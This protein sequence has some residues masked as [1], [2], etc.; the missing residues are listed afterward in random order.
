[1]DLRSRKAFADRHLAGTLSF[2]LDGPMATW[3]GWLAPWGTPLTLLGESAEQ[4]AAAQRELARI[5]I[6]RPAAAST[7]TVEQW[8]GHDPD[9][10]ADL[11]TATFSDLAA[12]RTG[13][14]A[15]AR[16]GEPTGARA[17]EPAG[18]L[19]VLDV[20]MGNEWRAGHVA[21]AVHIPLPEL[22]GRL[23]E[24]PEGT[25]WVHCGS[26]Y[27]AAAA[28]SLLARSGRQVVHIDDAYS[29][30]ADAGLPITTS[31]DKPS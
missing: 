29:H 24:V 16:A 10:I 15:T 12:A 31:D 20:R 23:A 2:G 28:A 8:A 27:R 6:D 22:P 11:T 9:L 30:A 17:G 25:V 1:M 13:E 7:G 3:L 18:G 19:T 21:G 26:G 14:P 5:G 4:V